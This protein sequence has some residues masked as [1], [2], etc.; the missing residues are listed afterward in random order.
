MKKYKGTVYLV[1]AGPGDVRLLT[2]K[3][4]EYLEKADVVLY[5]RLVNPLL[6][7]WTKPD[8]ELIY[9]GKLPDRHLLRQEAI[10]DLLVKKGKEG[11]VVVRLK[12]G[13]PSVFG[14]VGEEAAALEEAGV[15]YEII[16][17]IT[18]GIGAATYAGVPVTHRDHGASFAVI[19]GHDKSPTG[20]PMIDW[21]ALARG[22][23]TIAFY[24][25]VSN[26][27]HITEQ[28]MA[29]GRDKDTTVLLI[30][31]GTIGKQEVLKGTLK[32]IAQKAKDVQFKNPA[33][34]LVGDIGKLRTKKSWFEEQR[35]F[36]QQVLLG[37]T[38]SDSSHVA[39][40][41]REEGADVFEFPRWHQL[42]QL[43]EK[44]TLTKVM[45][46][47]RILFT[48]PASVHRFFSWLREEKIDIRQ[49]RAPFY[50]ISKKSL[51]AIESYA[52]AAFLAEE[53]TNKG[54]LVLF[55][56]VKSKAEREQLTE[57]WGDH[58]YIT[59]H[60]LQL[61]KQSIRT[62]QRLFDE[63][64]IQT[65]VF[66]SAASVQA[67]TDGMKECGESPASLSEGRTIISFGPT[68][69]QAAKEAGYMVHHELETPNIDIL[70]R[71]LEQQSIE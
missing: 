39:K 60:K 34:T 50:A 1:G 4:K 67:V 27:P 31:W 22:V 36:G 40:R 71:Y 25:G 6:L 18:A 41:L 21:E 68:T 10:N 14:R 37:R 62:C 11:K 61:V 45:D 58:D 47:E 46:S 65:I 29:N 24:M 70:I 3:G 20:Q 32:T 43:L 23:D 35:L 16:P 44:D 48:S 2:L 30:R 12:G 7:E 52:C 63:E 33:I 66:P 8:A 19:T 53:M 5:D 9:C 51:K 54:K 17:G 38:T 59:T 49:I 57:T 55:G 13:D 42:E 69:T 26:L 56:E 64:R 28:L 15:P